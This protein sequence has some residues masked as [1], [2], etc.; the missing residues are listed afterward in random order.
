M[1][2][3]VRKVSNKAVSGQKRQ[4]G[5]FKNKLFWIIA[6]VVVIIGVVIGIVI[7]VNLNRKN[8]S[9]K[10]GNQTDYFEL[11]EE[12]DFTRASYSGV[13]NYVNVNY[14]NPQNNENLFVTNVFV[15][16]YNLSSFYPD[17]ADKD[18]YNKNHEEL[19][20]KLKDLQK[21]VALAKTRGIDIELYIVDTSNGS[22]ISI[23]ADSTFGG[24]DDNSASFMFSFIQNGELVDDTIK[25]SPDRDVKLSSLDITYIKQTAI[26][27]AIEHVKRDLVA[28]E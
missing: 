26:P 19:L 7:G 1:A 5:I 13:K 23:M 3:V 27:Q 24:S 9:D 10:V 20:S 6:F 12:V 18:N 11:C 8:T 16:A 14:K 21:E 15:F 4:K 22:N 28:V 25:T 17:S 2:R